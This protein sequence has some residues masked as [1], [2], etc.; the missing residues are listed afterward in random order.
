[1]HAG[2]TLPCASRHSS[3]PP[4]IEP[5][6]NRSLR[7]VNSTARHL[8]GASDSGNHK[9]IPL[10]PGPLATIR[11][12]VLAEGRWRGHYEGLP[13]LRMPVATFRGHSLGGLFH[14]LLPPCSPLLCKTY[15]PTPTSG[16][17]HASRHPRTCFGFESFV[18]CMCCVS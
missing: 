2:S 5:L 14:A 17:V 15:S 13:C 16:V 4:E 6:C 11:S 12:E 3:S 9:G 18:F 8:F 1:M 10:F 7:Y